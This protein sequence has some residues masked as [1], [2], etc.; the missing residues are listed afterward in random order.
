[1]PVVD[2][3]DPTALQHLSIR[4][5]S[6]LFVDRVTALEVA[7]SGG[8]VYAKNVSVSP[9]VQSPLPLKHGP[10]RFG[11]AC[12]VFALYEMTDARKDASCV[13]PRKESFLP[14]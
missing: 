4:D 1:M 3:T 11:N 9:S 5:A 13:V 6:N 14:L 10:D 12:R 8:A 2:W 7:V